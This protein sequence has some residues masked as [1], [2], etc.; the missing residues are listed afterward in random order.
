MVIGCIYEKN[1]EGVVEVACLMLHVFDICIP[2][3]VAPVLQYG[4]GHTKWSC[5][6]SGM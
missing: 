4:Y 2:I 1:L 6:F 5:I 3:F